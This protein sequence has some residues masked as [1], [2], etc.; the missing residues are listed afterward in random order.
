MVFLLS[1]FVWLIVQHVVVVYL[2]G[3]WEF[4]LACLAA[5]EVMAMFVLADFPMGAGFTFAY[6]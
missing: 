5:Q 2:D 1:P 3:Y 6:E 4:Q